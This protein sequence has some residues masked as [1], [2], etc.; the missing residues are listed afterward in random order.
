MSADS[1]THGFIHLRDNPGAEEET[2]VV[3][4]DNLAVIDAVISNVSEWG[5]RL[6]S[7]DIRELYK[8]I[9]IRAGNTGKLVKAVVTSVKGS[10]AAVLFPKTEKVVTDKRREKRNN[11]KIPVKVSDLEGI[12]EISGV[13]V[14]AGNNGCRI[15]ATGLAGLPEEV[16]L[17]IGKM[18]RPVA[19]EFAWRSGGNAGLR[20][21]WDRTLE[22]LSDEEDED[23]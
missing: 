1:N 19:A 17:N 23:A 6:T 15:T 11:V 16:V 13:I 12:T 2:L 14:D 8:N 10:D 21:L 9:G 5:C 3:D 22:Q 4:F 20:L 7:A 18:E